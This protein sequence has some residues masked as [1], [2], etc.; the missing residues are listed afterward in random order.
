MCVKALQFEEVKKT[1]PWE[2]R[3]IFISQRTWAM[4][5][6]D[7]YQKLTMFC[8]S[9]WVSSRGPAWWLTMCV[10]G[11][12]SNWVGKLSCVLVFF[13]DWFSSG[14]KDGISSWKHGVGQLRWGALPG[15]GREM[16]KRRIG[17]IYPNRSF[18]WQ[19]TAGPAWKPSTYFFLCE[20]QQILWS[21]TNNQAKDSTWL[22]RGSP[23][24]VSICKVY[25]WKGVFCNMWG[26]TLCLISLLPWNVDQID[27]VFICVFLI[28]LLFLIK[29][30][31][32]AGLFS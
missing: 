32:G 5:R 6:A 29:W 18:Q 25:L 7:C 30:T 24:P 27:V 19:Q 21:F 15:K 13:W 8:W 2:E 4:L 9:V 23:E 16:R 31:C 1:F 26:L 14:L 22:C 3:H 20:F 17:P 12:L 10:H 11:W 28:L